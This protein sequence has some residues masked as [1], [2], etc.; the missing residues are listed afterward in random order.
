MKIIHKLFVFI[1][2]LFLGM[3]IPYGLVASL[4]N[5]ILPYLDFS[6]DVFDFVTAFIHRALQF[7]LS[8]LIF[9]ILF[10]NLKGLRL[11]R[12]EKDNN[13]LFFS[14]FIFLTWPLVI[15]IFFIFAHFYIDGFNDYIKMDYPLSGLYPILLPLRDFLLLDA[16]AEEVLYRGL[17]I[18]ILSKVFTKKTHWKILNISSAA[19][20]SIPI[21][22]VAHIQV[23]FFPFKILFYDEIQLILTLF[24]GY[25][26]V[27]AYEDTKGLLMPILLHGYTNLV[28]SLTAYA[29][30]LTL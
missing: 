24:T 19:L 30:L 11:F 9:R 27:K 17:I 18:V 26:F 3:F 4:V 22:V 13:S 20:L 10:K 5:L 29:Y 12:M 23:D 8:L 21:F 1:F 15:I 16:L 14:K 28:I 25:I 6:R 2:C 7:F